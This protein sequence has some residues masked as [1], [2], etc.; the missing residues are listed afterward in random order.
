[1]MKRIY[2]ILAAVLICSVHANAAGNRYFTKTGFIS[3][4]SA[5]PLI[6]IE[7]T[8]NSVTGFLD[9]KTGE[10]VFAVFI[11]DFRFK[12]A[13]AEEHFNENY[14]FSEKYPQSKFKGKILNINDLDLTKDGT[15]FVNVEG[16]LTI[17]DRTNPV[18]VKGS[19]VV[20][21]GKIDA[22]SEFSVLLKDY[23]IEVPK[24]VEDKVAKVIPIKVR[25]IYEEYKK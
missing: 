12:L 16:N 20:K 21:D 15:Y 13:L 7:G 4:I 17:K 18:T 19:L 5:T 8:N 23:N 2:I 9:I 22:R 1:M 14:M 10:I 11:K 24:I 3:F 6:D 25:M